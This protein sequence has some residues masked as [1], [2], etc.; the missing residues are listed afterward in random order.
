MTISFLN[1]IAMD[2]EKIKEL[3]HTSFTSDFTF[4]GDKFLKPILIEFIKNKN[5]EFMTEETIQ[6]VI[7][8]FKNINKKN[9]LII[10]HFQKYNLGRFYA[11]SNS[12]LIGITKHIKH[13]LLKHYGYMDLDI[14]KSNPSIIYALL[15]GILPLPS[16][17]E[18]IENTDEV[19]TELTTFYALDDTL[20]HKHI[21]EFFNSSIFGGSYNKWIDTLENEGVKFKTKEQHLFMK[22]F[23]DECDK[24]KSQIINANP[25]LMEYL[26]TCKMNDNNPVDEWKLNNSVLSYY[27]NTIENHILHIAYKFLTTT[28][29]IQPKKN[30]LLEYDGLCFKPLQELNETDLIDIATKINQKVLKDTGLNIKFKFKKYD[31]KYIHNEVVNQAIENPQTSL[32]SITIYEEDL[33]NVVINATEYDIA[34]YFCKIYGDNYKCVDVKNKIC[35]YFNENCLWD[36]FESGTK[37]REQ[38]SN[39]F[40]EIFNKLQTDIQDEMS[41]LEDEEELL[42]KLHRKVKKISEIT[43]KLKS[44]NSKNNIVREILDILFDGEFEKTLNKQHFIPIKGKKVIDL[45]TKEVFDRT[46]QHYYNYECPAEYFAEIPKDKYDYVDKYFLDL[47]CGNKEIKDI[48][49]NIFKSVFA[50]NKLRYIFFLIGDGSNGKSLLFNIL[51]YIFKNNMDTIDTRIILKTKSNSNLTTEY[52]K[53][54]HTKLAYVTELKDTDELN[55]DLIK[56]ISGGDVMDCRP[57]YKDNVT[58]TPVSTLFALTNQMGKC[59]P[60]DVAF[61]INRCFLIPFLNHFEINN[62][63]FNELKEEASYIFSYIVNYG[64]IISKLENLPKEMLIAK[65]TYTENNEKIDHYRNFIDEKFVAGTSKDKILYSQFRDMFNAYL[66][67]KGEQT[68]KLN[69]N[70]FT[71]LM[72]TKYKIASKQSNNKSYYVGLKIKEDEDIDESDSDSDNESKSKK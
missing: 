43:I 54:A 61:L 10:K 7:T 48:V 22:D 68:N 72:N 28:K 30:I 4:Q 63:L 19:F 5:V 31:D 21:K 58:I 16:F 56:K 41:S 37:I 15:N 39:E 71:R 23:K 29:T 60:N 64:T 17:K 8:I 33:E 26:R 67:S 13:T 59:D 44:T 65:Q 1:T 36:K 32:K 49:I 53:L 42:E 3:K 70:C 12:N 20:Q 51:S 9:Q 46:I 40:T 18:Y 27:L 35:Y 25:T 14:V 2:M 34:K 50:G 47:F 55:T 62:N 57:L 52:N 38:L 69:N 66:K 45:N 11:N 6:Q 24:V